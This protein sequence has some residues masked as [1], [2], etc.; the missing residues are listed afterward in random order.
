MPQ[1]NSQISLISR[2]CLNAVPAT[3][4]KARPNWPLKANRARQIYHRPNR[5]AHVSLA[6]LEPYARFNSGARKIETFYVG[7]CAHAA[8]QIKATVES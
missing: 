3:P 1:Y 8:F 4:P 2:D 6:I 5:I 7:S